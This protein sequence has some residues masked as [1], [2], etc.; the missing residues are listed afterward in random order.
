[1]I[2]IALNSVVSYSN[3]HL[4]IIFQPIIYDIFQRINGMNFAAKLCYLV[5]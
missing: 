1:M 3:N 4:N 2:M 5:G